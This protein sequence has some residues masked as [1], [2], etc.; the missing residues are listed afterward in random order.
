MQGFFIRFLVVFF[1]ASTP[2][3]R[4]QDKQAQVPPFLQ[5]SYFEVNVGAIHYPFG[6]ANLEPT[7]L[8]QS[9][10]EIPAAAVRLVLFGYEFN[11]ILSAQITYMRP[12]IWVHYG[13]IGQSKNGQLTSDIPTSYKMVRMNVGGL[14]LKS[15]LPISN[16]FS[17]YGEAGL[18][19]I[20]RKGFA[21]KLENQVVADA[22]YA[23]FLFGA[24]LKYHINS[25]WAL[26]VGANYSPEN[27]R[28]KQ[29]ATTFVGSGFV[30]N[31]RPF[32]VKRLQDGINYGYKHPKQWMQVAYTSNT[33]GYA[34]NN[35]VSDKIPLFW[36]GEAEVR[37]G[38]SVSYF[39]NVF[40]GPKVFALDWGV[41]ASVWQTNVNRENFFTLSVFPV[42]RLN[43]WHAHAFDAYFYY[44]VAGPSYISKTELDN[45][46]MGSHFTFQDNM[47]TGIFWGAKRNLNTEI[48]IGHYSNGNTSVENE[49]VKVP[50]TLGLGYVF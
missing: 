8:L 16:R 6:Q 32:T 41:N 47:G 37:Q 20:T 25:K 39:R 7:Y 2:F 17:L 14:T 11:K 10:V 30:Y 24:G 9:A 45:N 34:V 13:Q 46:K 43:Y 19:T 49:A 28:Y 12:V 5:K 35:A 4:A 40:H 31:F 36:G 38:I 3:L 21:D 23:T 18:G 42:F 50:L 22:N 48:R 1:S 15:T 44:S 29:P 33:L 26:Q 27:K